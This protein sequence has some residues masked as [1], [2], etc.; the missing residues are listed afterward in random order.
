MSEP[1]L[2]A[3]T[4]L[5]TYRGDVPLT[6]ATGFF[7]ERDGRAWLV[8]SAHVVFDGATGHAPD[9]LEAEVHLDRVDLTRSR[10]LRLPLHRD[11]VPLWRQASD[12]G[13]V[14]DVAV[15][16]IGADALADTDAWEAF[17]PAHLEGALDEIEVGEPVLIVGFP[18][19]FH[20]TL[21]HL[22]VARQA[23]IA[24]SF[25][26]RFQG[27]GCF[28]TD[29]RTHRGT[30][31]APVVARA[32]HGALAR[33]RLPWRLLGVHASRMDMGS[34]D[35]E[36]DESLGLNAAWYADVLLALTRR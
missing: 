36:L 1:V 16:P 30:S 29:A 6:R 5:S 7:F 32:R 31:G 22:P 2:H 12:S 19:G 13:G 3:C 35:R 18:L 23:G 8:T 10:V 20:D 4:P 11:G 33:A 14:V 9:R 34:R 28:L 24:S 21:H 27:R 17:T 25:G 15:V 26:V